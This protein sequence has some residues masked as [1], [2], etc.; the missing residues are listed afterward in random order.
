M[1][2][3]VP[4][5]F[6]VHIV[7]RPIDV[8]EMF[9]LQSEVADFSTELEGGA[10]FVVALRRRENDPSLYDDVDVCGA[11]G[12]LLGH[13][14]DER[15]EFESRVA[16]GIIRCMK[17]IAQRRRA[18]V[19]GGGNPLHRRL[20]FASAPPSET[21]AELAWRGHTPVCDHERRRRP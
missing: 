14:E 10:A 16:G 11:P 6:L 13:A 4:R 17:D 15:A 19:A 20:R 5:S 2:D 12:R 21:V 9:V 18:D 1:K 7:V 3:R 8:N